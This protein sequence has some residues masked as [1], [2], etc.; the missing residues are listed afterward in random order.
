MACGVQGHQEED[1]MPGG[2]GRG[3]QER[4]G[5]LKEPCLEE[6]RNSFIELDE[7]E[8]STPATGYDKERK[9]RGDADSLPQGRVRGDYQNIE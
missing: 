4:K 7:E 5:L 1:G 2:E 8:V 6:T 9:E 3:H